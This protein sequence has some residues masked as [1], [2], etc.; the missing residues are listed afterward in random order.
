MK[1]ENNISDMLNK[2]LFQAT[3]SDLVEMCIRDR[4][5][6]I[7]AALTGKDILG[8]AQTGT[9]KT[10]AFAIPIIPVSYTHLDVYKRQVHEHGG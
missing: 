4:V 10:A 1:S 9:G 5:K 8:C 6:A 7:P 3:V 2:P